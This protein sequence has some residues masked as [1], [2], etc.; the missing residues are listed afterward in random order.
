MAIINRQ[1][2]VLGA[3]HPVPDWFPG[4]R[5]T[6]IVRRVAPPEDVGEFRCMPKGTLLFDRAV[7]PE[8]TVKLDPHRQFVAPSLTQIEAADVPA[9]GYR[10]IND[11]VCW[12]HGGGTDSPFLAYLENDAVILAI[13]FRSDTIFFRIGDRRVMFEC[14]PARGLEALVVCR[15]TPQR[16]SMTY[17]AA[18]ASGTKTTSNSGVCTLPN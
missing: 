1:L 8:G 13:G 7:I 10:F 9:G 17:D 2:M 18:E 14:T 6:I 12:R 3:I 15:W 16:T 11:V 4:N 5:G